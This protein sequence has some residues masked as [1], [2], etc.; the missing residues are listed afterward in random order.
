MQAKVHKTVAQIAHHHRDG[1]TSHAAREL[2]PAGDILSLRATQHM[3]LPQAR[4][5]TVRALAGTVWI[6]QDGDIRDVVLEAGDCIVLDRD[7]PALFS[8]LGDARISL[9][10]ETGRCTSVR[11]AVHVVAARPAFA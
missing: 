3:H 8:P 11:E 10:R 2:N 6:A 9:S 1:A 5:W 4:G 7:T